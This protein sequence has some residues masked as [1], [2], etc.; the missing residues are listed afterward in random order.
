M[1]FR[2]GVPLH[3]TVHRKVLYTNRGFLRAGLVDLPLGELA[4]STGIA[5]VSTV[6][7]SVTEHLEAEHPDGKRSVL[8]A[9]GGI[10]LV[11]ALADVLSFGLNSVF[12][13]DGD[14]VR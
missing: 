12:S 11:D 14:L 9:T 10:D 8:V 3:S 5:P 2:Q 4:P 6:T 13:R 1:Y 7:L